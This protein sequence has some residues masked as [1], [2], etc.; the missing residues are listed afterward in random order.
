M[1]RP[2]CLITGSRYGLGLAL[3]HQLAD[4]WD[5][6]EYDLEL[7]HDL[8]EPLVQDQVVEDLKS[9]QVFF[10]NCDHQG[11]VQLL[12]RAHSLQSGL[13]IINSNSAVNY[14]QADPELL[15]WPE[16]QQYY[17]RKRRLD[18]E[19]QRIHHEQQNH[20]N[21]HS[22]VINLRLAWMDSPEHA[23]RSVDKMDLGDVAAFCAHVIAQ[24]PRLAVQDILLVSPR[25]SL[26]DAQSG[27]TLA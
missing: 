3:V 26:I 11:Q 7:G 5:I 25:R 12:A 2:R 27:E 9:C 17:E 16:W 22:W 21:L 13:C 1:T 10:N 6:T 8:D 19:I 14:Y 24:W 15:A 18:Q 23:L 4:Q 20:V